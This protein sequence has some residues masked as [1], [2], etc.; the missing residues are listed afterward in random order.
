MVIKCQGC[1]VDIEIDSTA[2]SRCGGKHDKWV[3]AKAWLL[4]YCCACAVQHGWPQKD[5]DKHAC[6]QCLKRQGL[7]PRE[8][9][10]TMSR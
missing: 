5:H 2:P 8:E 4:A 10:K 3:A 6:D 7:P 9:K 1:K